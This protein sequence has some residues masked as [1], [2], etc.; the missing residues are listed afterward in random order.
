ML[1]DELTGTAQRI[2]ERAEEQSEKL[3]AAAEKMVSASAKIAVAGALAGVTGAV[4]IVGKVAALGTG[5]A[6]QQGEDASG[7]VMALKGKA[8]SEEVFGK[9][10]S[11]LG[12]AKDEAFGLK[13]SI[14]NKLA[15]SA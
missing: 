9:A 7:Y 13:E 8:L 12:A 6:M 15:G 11:T 5:L 1:S 10:K 14:R 2:Q 3:N 4:S